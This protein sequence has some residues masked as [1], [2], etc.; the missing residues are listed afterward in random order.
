MLTNRIIKIEIRFYDS[1]DSYDTR[2]YK[3][4]TQLQPSPP[5]PPPPTVNTELTIST[6]GI[7][8]KATPRRIFTRLTIITQRAKNTPNYTKATLW[9]SATML[10]A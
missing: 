1:Y 6:R 8:T 3:C 10:R 2:E 9:F 4:Q 5:Q 7:D